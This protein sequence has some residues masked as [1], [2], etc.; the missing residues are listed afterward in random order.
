[1]AR[2]GGIRHVRG[3]VFRVGEL[4]PHGERTIFPVGLRDAREISPLLQ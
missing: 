4:R 3:R 2:L 1:M